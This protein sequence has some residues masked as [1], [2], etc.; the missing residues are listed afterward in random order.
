M[1][2]VD[3]HQAEQVVRAIYVTSAQLRQTLLELEG[4]DVSLRRLAQWATSGLLVPSIDWAGKRGAKR[5]YSL[6]DVVRGRLIVSLMQH[7]VSPQAARV[8]LVWL[9]GKV[10]RWERSTA[11]GTRVLI[12][13]RGRVELHEGDTVTELPL[14]KGLGGQ[15][16]LKLEDVR[17]GVREAMERARRIA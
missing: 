8:L 16:R 3:R 13:Q 11:R 12:V 14:K 6:D 7:G 4:E 15:Y 1:I 10:D 2:F 5:L 9:D 17:T